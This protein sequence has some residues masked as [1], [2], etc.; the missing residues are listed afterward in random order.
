VKD[1]RE[2][3]DPTRNDVKLARTLQTLQQGDRITLSVAFM[4]ERERISNEN[5]TFLAVCQ[6]YYF[7]LTKQSLRRNTSKMDH[8]KMSRQCADDSGVPSCEKSAHLSPI[9]Q[10]PTDNIQ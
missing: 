4:G 3:G 6:T 10:H 2:L 5:V 1:A 7:E 9:S 8:H